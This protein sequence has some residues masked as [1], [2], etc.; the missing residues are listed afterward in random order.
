MHFLPISIYSP[1]DNR[2]NGKNDQLGTR[3]TYTIKLPI[4]RVFLFEFFQLSYVFDDLS[5]KQSSI[6]V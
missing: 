3:R 4:F 5:P 6:V 2:L 1:K